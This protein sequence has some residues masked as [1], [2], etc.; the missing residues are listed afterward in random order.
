M[1]DA[2]K[3]A[4]FWSA[5]LLVCCLPARLA[6]AQT[7]KLEATVTIRLYNYAAVSPKTLARARQETNT[8]FRDTGIRLSWVECGPSE[9]DTEKFLACE[10]VGDSW[11]PIIQVIRRTPRELARSDA[12]P[13]GAAL[14]KR[15]AVF[16]DRIKAVAENM[17]IPVSVVLGCAM[18]HELGHILMGMG[19]DAH[20]QGI[21]TARLGRSELAQAEKGR[22]VFTSQQT[23]RMRARLLE[24]RLA[25]R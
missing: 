18:A 1:G 19:N 3:R 6:E 9:Q 15:A 2:I 17:G 5:V 12:A 14:G 8:V 20:G 4:L 10:Q 16:Y 23:E 13:A 24:E 25:A 21:M 22:L 7:P 11:A